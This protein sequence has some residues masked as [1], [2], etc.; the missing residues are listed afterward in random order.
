MRTDLDYKV[1]TQVRH[2]SDTCSERHRLSGVP[3][4]IGA[5]KRGARLHLPAGQV[6]DEGQGGR[7]KC[8]TAK[9][10]FQLDEGWFDQGAVK[11]AGCV[12]P[13]YPDAL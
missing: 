5:I 3:P 12:Q 13:S 8:H 4:P 2:C 10:G 1:H 11:R 9:E 7:L 6:A